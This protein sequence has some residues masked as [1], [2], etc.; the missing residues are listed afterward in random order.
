VVRLPWWLLVLVLA[1]AAGCKNESS[2]PPTNPGELP[3]SGPIGP[4]KKLPPP[5]PRLP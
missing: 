4:G 1:A 3:K 2:G 5:P